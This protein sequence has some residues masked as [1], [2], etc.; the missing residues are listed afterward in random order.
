MVVI[1]PWHQ[2]EFNIK[3]GD[4]ETGMRL[5]TF[6]VEVRDEA[7]WIESPGKT[8]EEGWEVVKFEPISEGK[9]HFWGQS[10]GL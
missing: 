8:G 3:T 6:E 2:Y 9:A 7:V 4:S 1:C 10:F 5:C